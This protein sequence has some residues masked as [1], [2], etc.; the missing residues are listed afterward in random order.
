VGTDISCYAE[1]KID[2]K[3]LL[4]EPLT[5]NGL[6][7]EEFPDEEPRLA[8]QPLFDTRNYALFAIL[9]DVR[10]DVRLVE[11]FV[12]IAA[13]RGFPDDASPELQ[14]YFGYWRNDAHNA[15]WLLASE[16]LAFDWERIIRRRGVVDARAAHLFPPSRTG[17]PNAA[18]PP[19]VE[20][21]VANYG[22]GIEVQWRETYRQAVGPELID[23]ILP[24]LATYGT[25]EAVRVVFWFES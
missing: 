12:F 4:A 11:P 10:N 1:K 2:G 9:A 6:W 21:G 14:D 23:A 19:G 8:P 22:S 3:W 5:A 24:G 17:F 25:A 7:S 16:I 18:W 13:P 15:G 20:Q